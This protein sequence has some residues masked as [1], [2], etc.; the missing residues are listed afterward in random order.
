[1]FTGIIEE[2][3]EVVLVDRSDESARLTVRGQVVTADA[4]PGDSI[5]V[6]GVCLTVAERSGHTF[7]ADVMLET[8]QRSALGDLTSGSRVNLERPIPAAGRFGG[9][10]VQGHVDGVGR[11]LERSPGERWEA[12]RIALPGEL[13]R[14]VVEKGSITL[15]GV[16][17][18]VAH[19]A[20]SHPDAV[21]G[22]DTPGGSVVTVFLIPE[23]LARTTLGVR[24]LGDAVNVE[25]DVLGKYVERLL[26]AR[27]VQP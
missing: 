20:D 7:T 16:S 27:A 26:A 9:H 18:T 4:G 19:V 8:L 15:D 2:L 23:T 10:L 24:D 3:G 6:N 14:Y 13:S 25:V 21:L 17:L 22:G 11:V 5:A 1:M 12:L